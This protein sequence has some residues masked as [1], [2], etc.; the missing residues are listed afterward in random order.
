M[1][2]AMP[3]LDLA[4]VDTSAWVAFLNRADRNHQ[5]SVDELVLWPSHALLTTSHVADELSRLAPIYDDR[6][7]AITFAL[8]VWR[9]D[10]AYV[11]DPGAEI[12]RRAWRV[13]KKARAQGAS[14]VDCISAAVITEYEIENVIA[15]GSGLG[16]L[17]DSNGL[18]TQAQE[19]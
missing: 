19:E 3:R 2:R 6:V 7:V 10:F 9:G 16:R 13:F 14:F 18:G 11:L 8:H 4:F 17:L 1:M 12:E 15:Y 5:S